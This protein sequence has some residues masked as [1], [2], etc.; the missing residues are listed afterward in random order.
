[1]FSFDTKGRMTASVSLSSW[2]W[3]EEW[4]HIGEVLYPRKAVAFPPN[5]WNAVFLLEPKFYF[6]SAA[7][8]NSCD[9]VI[10]DIWQCGVIPIHV[11]LAYGGTIFWWK[12]WVWKWG[13]HQTIKMWWGRWGNR[14]RKWWTAMHNPPPHTHTIF[15]PAAFLVVTENPSRVKWLGYKDEAVGRVVVL[16]HFPSN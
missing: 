4:A 7:W 10:A 5:Q 16:Y 14:R 13:H 3:N 8:R 15:H 2:V 9:I 12:T 11:N 1:M 6:S